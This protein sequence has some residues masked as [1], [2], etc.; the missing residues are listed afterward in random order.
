MTKCSLYYEMDMWL[1]GS[2]GQ[3]VNL[4]NVPCRLMCRRCGTVAASLAA[5]CDGMT[6]S[7]LHYERL[8]TAGAA[9]LGGD[10]N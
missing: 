5:H 3:N 1:W 6:G 2:Q 8:V 4:R 10:G 7:T 9:I